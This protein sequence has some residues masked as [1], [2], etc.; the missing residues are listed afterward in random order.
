[1]PCWSSRREPAE[2]LGFRDDRLLELVEQHALV[3]RVDVA[4]A[5][6]GARR[7]I[8]ASGTVACNAS[9]SG[10]EPPVATLTVG[11]PQAAASAS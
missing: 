9:T 8:S 4:V 5:V 11:L 10:I 1:V 2:E 3:R 7:R 6:G